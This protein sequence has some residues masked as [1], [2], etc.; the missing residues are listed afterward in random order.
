[1]TLATLFLLLSV[2]GETPAAAT[3]EAGGVSVDG[4]LVRGTALSVREGAGRLLLVSGASVEPL[5]AEAVIS[6]EGRTMSVAPGVR[7][8]RAADGYVL[9]VHGRKRVAVTLGGERHALLAPVTVKPAAGGWD[10]GSGLVRQGQE[11]AA[12]PDQDDVDSNLNKL[13]QSSQKIQKATA[14]PAK[15]DPAATTTSP[16][17]GPAPAAKSAPLNENQAHHP[18]NSPPR[19]LTRP[20]TPGPDYFMFYS[21]FNPFVSAQAVSSEAVRGSSPVSPLGP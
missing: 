7:V 12:A 18:L 13:N 2:G 5:S 14:P 19:T 15:Q 21:A 20:G 3:F 4:A 1:M 11:L 16:P 10:L 17:P 8:T 9:S 6:A